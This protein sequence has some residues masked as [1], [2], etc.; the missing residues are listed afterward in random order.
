MNRVHLHGRLTKDV[1]LRETPTGAKIARF[2]VAV[3]RRGKDK[4]ADFINCQAWNGT[5]E[6]IARFLHKGSEIVIDD[7]SIRTGSY[8]N[9]QGQKVY[10]TDVIVNSFD[11]C[12]SKST[13]PAHT[14]RSSSIYPDQLN[15]GF[16]DFEIDED[17][18]LPF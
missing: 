5:A 16:D 15:T 7:G 1:D 9:N 14:P 17:E 6:T 10:T 13:A 8:T 4:G 12:G 2:T 18:D 3:D 11:F